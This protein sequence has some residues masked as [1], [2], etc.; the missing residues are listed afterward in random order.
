VR[1][2]S[3]VARSG[4]DATRRLTPLRGTMAKRAPS[5]RKRHDKRSADGSPPGCKVCRDEL[6][7]FEKPH[8]VNVFVRQ[9]AGGDL[10]GLRRVVVQEPTSVSE[11]DGRI[12]YQND[13]VYRCTECKAWWLSQYWEVETPETEDDEFGHRYWRQL[14]LSSTQIA[15]IRVAIKSGRKLQHDEFAPSPSRRRFVEDRSTTPV[16]RS[17]RR[18]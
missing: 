2:L 14:P 7:S 16:K 6:T 12:T 17:V 1:E 18:S 8:L 10:S 4:R 11:P 15:L 9:L 13:L 5:K 3:K